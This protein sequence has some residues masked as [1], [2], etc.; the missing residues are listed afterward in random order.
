MP[1][2]DLPSPEL[3]QQLALQKR[4]EEIVAEV[5]ANRSVMALI[6]RGLASEKAGKLINVKDLK[7][8]YA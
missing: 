1:S 5:F 6:Q 3:A 8:K 2:K 7:R 4:S